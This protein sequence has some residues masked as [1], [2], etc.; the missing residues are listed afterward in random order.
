MEASALIEKL[1]TINDFGMQEFWDKNFNGACPCFNGEKTVDGKTI[2]FWGR[3]W[4]VSDN[5]QD[6][7][8]WGTIDLKNKRLIAKEVKRALDAQ[9][10]YMPYTIIF[11]EEENSK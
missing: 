6:L 4:R 3:C 1:K 11:D 2:G 10:W 8:V 7:H 9:E 5:G